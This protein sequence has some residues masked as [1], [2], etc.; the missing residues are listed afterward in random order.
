VLAQ[1]EA[2]HDDLGLDAGEVAAAVSLA[3]EAGLARLGDG[4]AALRLVEEIA[5]GTP[6]G[7]I[8]G[9]GVRV[10]ADTFG[11]A[12]RRPVPERAAASRDGGAVGAAR[13]ELGSV[14]R[15]VLEAERRF[16]ARARAAAAEH[17][18]G[19]AEPAV[20]AHPIVFGA[21]DDDVARLFGVLDADADPFDPQLQL[22]IGLRP[23]HPAGPRLAGPSR[24]VRPRSRRN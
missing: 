22:P 15:D 17:G 3:M 10:V 16:E 4:Q 20:S 19:P 1:L 13:A 6:L 11:L 14:A 21:V 8:V 18:T 24:T 5:R 2:L 7:R 12:R 23:S 9:S